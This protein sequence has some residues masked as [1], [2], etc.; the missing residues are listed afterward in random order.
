MKMD[1]N[2]AN[3]DPEK[4]VAIEKLK[5]LQVVEG[6]EMKVETLR[7]DRKGNIIIDCDIPS[8]RDWFESE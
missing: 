5:Y 6:L 3:Y 2:P 7:I 1:L 8:H 4:W